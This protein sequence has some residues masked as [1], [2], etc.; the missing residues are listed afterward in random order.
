[1]VK[2]LLKENI[3]RFIDESVQHFLMEAHGQS[4]ID[5]LND[6]IDEFDY[7]QNQIE[8]EIEKLEQ[9]IGFTWKEMQ[10]TS[11]YMPSDYAELLVKY[12]KLKEK[13]K[14]V[15]E[16]KYNSNIFSK[17][18]L[19]AHNAGLKRIGSGSSRTA[20]ELPINAYVLKLALNE[21]G[22][23]QNEQ[24]VKG[25]TN[26]AVKDIVP[27]IYPK[28]DLEN[29]YFLI[30]EKVKPYDSV[31]EFKLDKKYNFRIINVYVGDGGTGWKKYLLDEVNSHF[32]FTMNKT[33]TE[34]EL[35]SGEIMRYYGDINFGGDMTVEDA[36]NAFKDSHWIDEL[37]KLI[38]SE[39]LTSGDLYAEHFG[40]T[41]SGRVVFYDTGLSEDVYNRYYKRW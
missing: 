6:V 5:V 17:L 11:D 8:E 39:Q 10:Q 22:I 9:E 32:E 24:E 20:F 38:E 29:Y 28:S 18:L 37:A 26:P 3:K 14:Q 7:N 19:A 27:R 2:S 4:I 41:S 40:T 33:F 15:K 36:C 34:K 21:K 16:K 31:H 13:H 35:C 1:M 23:S 30:V 12:N 25:Y